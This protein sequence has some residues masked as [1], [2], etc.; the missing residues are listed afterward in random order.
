M[1]VADRTKE[2]QEAQKTLDL[3]H[4]EYTAELETSKGPIRLKFFPDVA[5]GHVRNFLALA[6][7][8]FY[9]GI[10]FH[11]IIKGFVIQAGCP[12]GTGTGGPGYAIRAEFNDRPHEEGTLSMARTNDP[13]SAGSQFFICLGR[14]ANLDNQYTVFGKTADEESLQTVRALGNVKTGRG[15]QPLEEAVI[16]KVMVTE[17]AK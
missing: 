2:V 1:A 6:K 17:S 5:P 16:K 15:D 13:N 12:L 11:R 9:N 4:K 3:E 7:I 10:K 8:G 14:V